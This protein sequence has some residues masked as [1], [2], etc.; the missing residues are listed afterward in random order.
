ME[1]FVFVNRLKH[2]VS[3]ETRPLRLILP[4]SGNMMWHLLHNILAILCMVFAFGSVTNSECG[5][6]LHTYVCMQA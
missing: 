4:P 3:H 5:R 2:V 1:S 6:Y